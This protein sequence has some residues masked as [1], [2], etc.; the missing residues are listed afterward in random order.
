[1]AQVPTTYRKDLALR[2]WNS[3]ASKGAIYTQAFK[4]VHV[5][6]SGVESLNKLTNS[7]CKTYFLRL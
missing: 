6:C 3:R 5:L 4:S 1:M 7:V 2:L